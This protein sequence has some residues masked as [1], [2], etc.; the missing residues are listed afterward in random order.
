MLYTKTKDN[1]Q[2]YLYY[3]VNGKSMDIKQRIDELRIKKGWSLSRL[4]LEIGVSDNTV[5]SWYNEK[6][7]QPSRKTTEDICN[8]F[9]ITLAEF[10]SDIDFDKLTSKEIVL[11]EAFRNVSDEDKQ[12]VIEIV[13]LFENKQNK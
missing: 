13:K 4:A 5:Y 1:I 6:K 10:Y 7:Y 11:L 3:L 12:R 9:N 2:I 8:V